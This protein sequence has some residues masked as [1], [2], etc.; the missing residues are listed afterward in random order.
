[1]YTPCVLGLRPFVLF[2]DMLTLSKN[3]KKKMLGWWV[4]FLLVD[5]TRVG[6]VEE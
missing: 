2:N 3:K 4:G 1:M 5:M 6:D